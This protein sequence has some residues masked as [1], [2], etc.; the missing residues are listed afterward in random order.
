MNQ[1]NPNPIGK[2]EPSLRADPA[3]LSNSANSA[4]AAP[5]IKL[6]HLV[7]RPSA[8]LAR[9]PAAGLHGDL[10][11]EDRDVLLSAVKARLRLTFSEPAAAS[12]PA[13]QRREKAAQARASVFECVAA[14]ERLHLGLTADAARSRQLKLDA[15]DALAAPS[16]AQAGFGVGG[17][18]EAHARQA[19]AQDT[20]TRLPNGIGFRERLREAVAQARPQRQEFAVLTLDLEGFERVQAGLGTDAA[21]ELLGIVAARLVRAVRGHDMVSRLRGDEFVLLIANVVSR[22]QLRRLTCKLF[23]AVAAPIAI[24]QQEVSVRPSFGIALGLADGASGAALI[25]HAGA[26]LGR[27]RRQQTGYA[28]YGERDRA[29]VPGRV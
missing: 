19:A 16:Q 9:D 1:A 24:R 8:P 2:A 20:L 28:F 18:D 22:E 4:A 5:E 3:V 29:W 25:K 15:F 14:L 12:M 11:A 17:N 10:E 23:D 13:A 26:A 6:L 21:D 27:A 7:A